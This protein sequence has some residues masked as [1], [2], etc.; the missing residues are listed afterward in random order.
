MKIG[1]K[2]KIKPNTAKKKDCES[3]FDFINDFTISCTTYSSELFIPNI[4]TKQNSRSKISLICVFASATALFRDSYIQANCKPY[5]VV[6]HTK[7]QHTLKLLTQRYTMHSLL[8]LF[9][10]VCKPVHMLGNMCTGEHKLL[11]L[12]YLCK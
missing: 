6:E 7:I 3:I 8:C 1:N 4:N 5:Q 12:P 2:L 9:A 10:S 11:T